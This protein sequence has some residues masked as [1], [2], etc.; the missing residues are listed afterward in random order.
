M[1][2]M[3]KKC[4]FEKGLIGLRQLSIFL[5]ILIS[6][7]GTLY[8]DDVSLATLEI[9]NLNGTS[10]LDYLK[11]MI[12][13]LLLFDLSSNGGIQMVD[14]RNIEAILDEQN[15]QLS[16]LT[17]GSSSLI[18]IGKIGAAD[19]LLKGTYVFL[20]TELLV[21]LS[22]FDTTTAG[23][24]TFTGRGYTENMIHQLAEEI[25]LHLTGQRVSLQDPD[26]MRSILSLKDETPGQISFYS[27]M[28]PAEIFIDGEFAGYTTGNSRTPIIFDD[29]S[30]G[31]H[32]IKLNAGEDFGM[33]NKPEFTFEPWNTDVEIRA[34][35]NK[36]IRDGTVDFN[37]V[38]YDSM[39]IVSERKTF[40][41]GFRGTE[42]FE[43][44]FSY[45]DREGNSVEGAFSLTAL[46]TEEKAV[47]SWTVTVDDKIMEEGLE[48][49][50]N[51][52]DDFKGPVGSLEWRIDSR[53]A[54]YDRVSLNYSLWRRDIAQGMYR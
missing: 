13:G 15:L 24:Q 9:E 20:G 14:R 41:D 21:S 36:V 53:F 30:P 35:K 4:L 17:A 46:I 48:V 43:S 18:E 50:F 2:N 45:V 19:Y 11:G 16:G 7:M 23:Q 8:A 39:Q 52:Y 40:F 44:D 54:Q 34:G 1:K 33:I 5:I 6:G 3:E 31:I 38:I 22:L 37:S 12:S 27:R 25:I 32:N 26:S 51:G 49:P 10:D 29:L 28:Y 42:V 47:Y